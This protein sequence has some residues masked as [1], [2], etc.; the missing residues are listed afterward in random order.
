MKQL[1]LALLMVTSSLSV[2]ADEVINISQSQLL[3]LLDAAKTPEFIVLDVR[4]EEEFK[5][6]H[7][8]GALNIS[9]DQISQQLDQLK[10]YKDKMII[11]H[12]RSGRRAQT[13]EAIL[14]SHQFNKLRHLK[15]DFKAWLAADLAIVTN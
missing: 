6:G 2:Q 1:F 5:Q 4:T 11:V 3:S 15:G 14:Q 7:I 12:C 10:Q 9:H 8:K 13:A